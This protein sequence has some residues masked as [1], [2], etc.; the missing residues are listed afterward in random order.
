MLEDCR[1]RYG[2]FF[3]LRLLDVGPITVLAH[4]DPIRRLFTLDPSLFSAG[5]A[6]RILSPLLGEQSVLVLDGPRHLRQRRLMLPPFHGER[7]KAYATAM[8]EATDEVVDRWPIG[9]PVSV[10]PGFQHITLQVILET[11]FGVDRGRMADLGEQLTRI[12]DFGTDPKVVLVAQFF[13]GPARR[14]RLE[15]F[16]EQRALADRMI[17]DEIERRRRE[18]HGE[19]ADV[20][21]LLMSATDEDGQPMSDEELRDQLMTLLAAGHETTATSLAW[22]VERLLSHRDVYDRLCDELA[23]VVGTDPVTDEHLGELVYLD[24]VVKESLRLRPVVPMVARRLHVP[25][26]VHGFELP[27]NTVVCPNIYLTQRNPEIYSEP[28]RFL[29]ERFVGTKPN[30]YA[31]FPFG[32]SIRRCIGMAFAVYE[33]KIV[34]AAMLSRV[35]LGLA[36]GTS[37]RMARRGITFAPADG[38]YVVATPRAAPA[39]RY[40]APDAAVSRNP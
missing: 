27:A 1:R 40:H 14:R 7:M 2:D 38:P 13:F 6:A 18:G 21:S 3:S 12:L 30:P 37:A 17:Y 15:H 20:M 31:W 24:A 34:L 26:M 36:R 19:R 16:A 23:R 32:G 4:P 28:E 39:V 11:V 22:T 33:M 10:R 8:R 35:N 9:E 25:M 29:P 5:E